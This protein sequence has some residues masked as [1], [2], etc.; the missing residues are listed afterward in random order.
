MHVTMQFNMGLSYDL[1]KLHAEAA[2]HAAAKAG[3]SYLEI[4]QQV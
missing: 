3:W 4:N 2:I 1:F